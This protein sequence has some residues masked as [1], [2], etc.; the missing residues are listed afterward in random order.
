[1]PTTA[2]RKTTMTGT[3]I[4]RWT[5]VALW[6]GVIFFMSSNTGSGLN[7]GLG[8]FSQIYQALKG[9]QAAIFGEG[10][11]VLSP[12]AHFLEYT[13]FGL[14]LSNALRS[15]LPLG[16]ACVLAVVLAS[17]YGVTDEFH[18][19]FVDGRMCDPLDW[20]TDTAGAALGAAIARLALRAVR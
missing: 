18:Q 5:L 3:V 8:L 15:H 6:A 2:D 13:V 14:L 20:L 9:V 7:E 12:A 1:M 17:L 19:L 4:V 11:D 16:R 10:A